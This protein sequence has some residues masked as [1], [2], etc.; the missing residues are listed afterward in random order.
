MAL[1]ARAH[2]VLQQPLVNLIGKT[3]KP[4]PLDRGRPSIPRRLRIR[5]HLRNT[6]PADPKIP[7]YPAPAQPILK[8]SA[9]NLQIQIHGENTPARPGV[10]KGKSGRLLR[11]PQPDHPAATVD[12]FCT[13]VLTPSETLS[14]VDSIVNPDRS[15]WW[16]RHRLESCHGFWWFSGSPG[17]GFRWRWWCR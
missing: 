14:D 4:G 13:A 10:R 9:P 15:A 7:C 8:M 2:F 5:Q 17:S 12:E 3:I 16:R 1:L 6:V 11:R